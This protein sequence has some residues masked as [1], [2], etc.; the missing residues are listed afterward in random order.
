VD[1]NK[2]ANS[3]AKLQKRYLFVPN[4]IHQGEK[5]YKSIYENQPEIKYLTIH[6]ASSIWKSV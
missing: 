4:R 3:A 6:L 2:K 5:D 1:Y